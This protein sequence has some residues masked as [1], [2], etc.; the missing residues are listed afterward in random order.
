MIASN[1]SELLLVNA[2]QAAVGRRRVITNPQRTYRYCKGYRH[3]LGKVAAVVC[4]KTSPEMWRALQVCVDFGA[5][6]IVQAAN[7]G[8]TGGSTPQGEYS[9]PIVLV[10]TGLLRGVQLI[11]GGKEAVCRAGATLDELEKSLAH[12]DRQ[13]HSVLGSSCL[14]AS[15]VGGI[16]NNSGGSLLNRGPAFTRH[17]IYA[18]VDEQGILTLENHL[19]LSLEGAPEEILERLDSL[20]LP[21]PTVDCSPDGSSEYIARI[22]DVDAYTPARFNADPTRLF[23]SAGCAGKLA[24]FAVR[25]PTFPSPSGK[26][27]IYL[28]TNDPKKLTG[29]RRD[30]LSNLEHLPLS[31]EYLDRSAFD[32]AHRYGKD[33]MLLIGALGTRRMPLLF[34]IKARFDR[35][36]HKTLPSFRHLSDKT[37]QWLSLRFPEHL[38]KRILTIGVTFEHHLIFTVDQ[39]ALEQTKKYIDRY[40][41]CSQSSY[42]LCNEREAKAALLHRYSAAGAAIRYSMLH[43]D[44]LAG[45]IS[46]DVALPRNSYCWYDHLPAELTTAID[47]AMVYGHFFCHVFHREYL[48][49]RTA[50]VEALEEILVAR[51]NEAGGKCPAEHNVG[52]KYKAEPQL[53]NFYKRVDPTN[54]FNPGIG[55]MSKEPFYR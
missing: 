35:F 29:L 38:P 34:A 24:V 8:L 37:L 22:R 36:F 18:R 40:F 44:A 39:A 41:N 51:V 13:P 19:G 3:G 42:I 52:H 32:L 54:T 15:V 12:I 26:V 55:G 23:E 49:K 20:Q 16:C 4:P 7:T 11:R 53:A 43:E 10:S 27:V 31:A 2:L 9:R 1:R 25:V 48:V 33:L 46:L 5:G 30:M 28:G 45:H 6:V 47:T 14:G 50:N 17:S 21:E